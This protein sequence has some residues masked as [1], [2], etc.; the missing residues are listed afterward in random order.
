MKYDRIVLCS[1]PCEIPSLR[2]AWNIAWFGYVYFYCPAENLFFDFGLILYAFLEIVDWFSV[3]RRTVVLHFLFARL[4]FR[5]L[6]L[7]LFWI[8]VASIQVLE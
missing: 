3:S 1:A 4:V 6:F 8:L 7:S 2:F 5:S